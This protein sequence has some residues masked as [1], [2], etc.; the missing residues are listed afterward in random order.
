MGMLIDLSHVSFD[1]MRDTLDITKAP[2]IFSHSSA[3]EVTKHARNVPDHEALKQWGPSYQVGRIRDLRK[4]HT[5]RK[6]FLSS[7]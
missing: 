6:G 5:Q 2:V 3:Y 7:H 1:T 4:L